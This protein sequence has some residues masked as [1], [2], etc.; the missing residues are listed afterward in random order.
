MN[1]LRHTLATAAFLVPLLL[2]RWQCL[3]RAH[4]HPRSKDGQAGDGKG[5]D[6]GGTL[7]SRSEDKNTDLSAVSR[8][9]TNWPEIP[10]IEKSQ[11]NE[12]KI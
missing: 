6:G 5:P 7:N 1:E 11:L 8:R 10:A 2:T 9:T 4:A 3:R 12:T